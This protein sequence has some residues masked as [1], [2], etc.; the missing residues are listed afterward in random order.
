MY[1][2][3]IVSGREGDLAVTVNYPAFGESDHPYYSED[4]KA[5]YMGK[6]MTE[7]RSS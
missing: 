1:N 6:E 3:L 2:V 7:E 5:V 4:G